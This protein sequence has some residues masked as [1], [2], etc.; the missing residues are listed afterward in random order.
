MQ[1]QEDRNAL[2]QIYLVDTVCT[3]V[4]AVMKQCNLLAMVLGRPMTSHRAKP[5][6]AK[7]IEYPCS[8]MQLAHKAHKIMH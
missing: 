8:G 3:C 7:S 2:R 6:Q 5:S 4:S 1:K